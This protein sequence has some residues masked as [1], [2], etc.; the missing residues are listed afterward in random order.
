[1]KEEF[2][3]YEMAL[4]LKDLEFVQDC[5][6]YYSSPDNLVINDLSNYQLEKYNLGIGAPLYQQI[7][8]WL[9]EKH[10]LLIKVSVGGDSNIYPKWIIDGILDISNPNC[11]IEWELKEL[12][13]GY[14]DIVFY[15]T[16]KE[17]LIAGIKHTLKLIK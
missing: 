16:Y 5:L 9:R 4:K 12:K 6:A 17:A 3:P 15:D 11:A 7:I 13:R 2:V 1:M 10:N 14:E 8:D